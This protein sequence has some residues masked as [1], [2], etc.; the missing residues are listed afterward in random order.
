MNNDDTLTSNG[1]RQG[2]SST[3]KQSSHGSTARSGGANEGTPGDNNSQI[4]VWR[5]AEIVSLEFSWMFSKQVRPQKEKQNISSTIVF[6]L[7]IFQLKFCN[8]VI[9]DSLQPNP[10]S[11]AD[12]AGA[13]ELDDG[14]EGPSVDKQVVLSKQRR[15]STHNNLP[16]TH[17]DRLGTDLFCLGHFIAK[18]RQTNELYSWLVLWKLSNCADINH[19]W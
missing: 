13:D 5:R 1:G 18:I 2:R 12:Q 14:A 9:N 19:L 10:D 17:D 8:N 6:Y 3:L 11:A 4:T 15:G 7:F 16:R